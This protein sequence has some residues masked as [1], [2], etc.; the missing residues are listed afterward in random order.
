MKVIKFLSP[1]NFMGRFF[2]ADSLHDPKKINIIEEVL[3]RWEKA[4]I[5]KFEDIPEEESKNLAEE[6]KISNKKNIELKDNRSNR[7][8]AEEKKSSKKK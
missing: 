7:I 2:A 8:K 6:V 5:I 4:Q 3:K 1:T